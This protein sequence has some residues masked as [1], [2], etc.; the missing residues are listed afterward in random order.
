M[1]DAVL[2][3][4]DRDL[5]EWSPSSELGSGV[6]VSCCTSPYVAMAELDRWPHNAIHRLV[7][8]LQARAQRESGRLR[9]EHEAELNAE[10]VA[11]EEAFG[12]QEPES[13][14]AFVSRLDLYD[15]H[16]TTLVL[17]ELQHHREDL[18]LILQQHLGERVDSH[19]G[20]SLA[21]LL[22]QLRVVL[23]PR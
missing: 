17:A 5:D 11:E 22:S 13:Y 3:A 6:C 15:R 12:W 2:D 23:A 7:R 16:A 9:A 1:I 20:R 8:A 18:D 4:L 14:P 19:V 10:L 21:I